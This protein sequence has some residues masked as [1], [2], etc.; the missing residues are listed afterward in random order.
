MNGDKQTTHLYPLVCRKVIMSPIVLKPGQLVPSNV[1]PGENWL[2]FQLK[3]LYDVSHGE[4][5]TNTELGTPRSRNLVTTYR[6]SP[7]LLQM[8]DDI[9]GMN[10]HDGGSNG[11]PLYPV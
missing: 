11:R 3:S 6:T 9:Q 8:S 2:V 1:P 4:S 7:P 5:N 10:A